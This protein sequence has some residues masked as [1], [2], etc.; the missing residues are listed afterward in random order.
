M[1]RR[2]LSLIMLRDRR[3]R[4]FQCPPLAPAAVVPEAEAEAVEAAAVFTPWIWTSSENA[5]APAAV[6]GAEETA[7]LLTPCVWKQARESTAAAAAAGGLG[8]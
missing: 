6:L 2:S 5:L 3:G 1:R 7:K 4:R 8:E